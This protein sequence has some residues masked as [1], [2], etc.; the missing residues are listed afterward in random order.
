MVMLLTVV[1]SATFA[2]T[3][4]KGGN[5]SNAEGTST[6][7]VNAMKGQSNLYVLSYVGDRSSKV[8]IAIYN[9]EDNLIMNEVIRDHTTFHRPYNFSALPYG[10]YK[11]EVK[12]DHGKKV[13][14]IHHKAPI[15]LKKTFVD[16]DYM[17]GRDRKLVMKI[18]NWKKEVIN[19]RI[20]DQ[21]NRLLHEESNS[22]KGAF[23]KVYDVK[24]TFSNK[25]TFEISN[26]DGL[27]QE[28]VCYRK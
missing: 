7:E 27:I 9:E 18:V 15:A 24:Q 8:T 5:K 19:I 23:C 10:T 6:M 2:N 16:V 21:N 20:F 14:T 3:T 17:G 25:F 12:D 11:L 26:E 1:S 28:L 22:F 13:N 4:I